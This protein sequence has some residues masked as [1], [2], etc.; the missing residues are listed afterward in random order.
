MLFLL[1]TLLLV[2]ARHLI[3]KNRGS[4]TEMAGRN[5]VRLCAASSPPQRRMIL[6]S[7][8][9]RNA[10]AFLDPFGSFYFGLPL[11]LGAFTVRV[12]AEEMTAPSSLDTTQRY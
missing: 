11:Q 5:A 9:V 1:Y 12:A 3:L 10:V 6:L 7:P 8:T 2:F 4:Q